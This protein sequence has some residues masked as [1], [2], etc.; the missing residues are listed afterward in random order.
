M[1]GKRFTRALVVTTAGT[2]IMASA[3]FA[4]VISNDLVVTVD[5]KVMALT[6]GGATGATAL[7]VS[8]ANG[9]NKNGCN[10]GGGGSPT[11]ITSVTSSNTAVATVSPASITWTSCGDAPTLTVTP[12]TAGTTTISLAQTSN[13]TGATFDLSPATFTVNVSAAAPTNTPPTQPGTP[14]LTSGASPNQGIFTLG[15]TA[16][17]DDGQPANSSVT[18]TL[19]HKNAADANF[20]NVATG[21]TTNSYAFTTPEAEGTWTYRVI[22]TDGTLSSTASDASSA[23]K[24]DR[25]NPNAPILSADRAAEDLTGGWYLNT[26]T[27]SFT[28]N[29]DPNLA[30]GS[31][32]SNV[33]ASRSHRR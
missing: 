20:S 24:V 4:D 11:L 3:A 15:W 21:L 22:A 10:F 31:T 29:G 5:G 23:V 26:V 9:D 28:S 13:S 32:G 27:V 30:D 16:S 14:S 33:N 18:Y 25:S 2:L 12:L 17:T 8:P 1:F 7:S 19:Q 6:A